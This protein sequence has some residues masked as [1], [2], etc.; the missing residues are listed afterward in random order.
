[1]IEKV[2]W[3][4]LFC[5]DLVFCTLCCKTETTSNFTYYLIVMTCTEATGHSSLLIWSLNA[6]ICWGKLLT[7]GFLDMFQGVPMRCWIRALLEKV[8]ANNHQC[9]CFSWLPPP[10]CFVHLSF[11]MCSVG[12]FQAPWVFLLF[13]INCVLAPLCFVSLYFSEEDHSAVADVG[14]NDSVFWN[15]V[16]LS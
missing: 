13:I 16:I 7:W 8:A 14:G 4:S 1:M 5:W 3:I 11:I 15:E 2:R 9:F 12:C 6:Q 10:L